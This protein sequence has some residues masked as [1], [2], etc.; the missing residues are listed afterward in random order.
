MLGE[1]GQILLI[2]ALLA[3][4]LQSV[5]PLLGAQR[6]LPSLIAVA[7]PAAWLQLA[8]V[9]GAFIVL[10]LAFVQQDFSLRYVADNS[11]T[12]LPLI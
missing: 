6:N 8:T 5:L 1:T 7:R 4:L 2:L 11:N 10:T 12:L 9:L 3:A